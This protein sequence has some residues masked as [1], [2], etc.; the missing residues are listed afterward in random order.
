METSS[1][2]IW[3]GS[4]WAIVAMISSSLFP[5]PLTYINSR[6]IKLFIFFLI[7][8]T[9]LPK[10]KCCVKRKCHSRE[11][12]NIMWH[13]VI[14]HLTPIHRVFRPGK[15]LRLL[16]FKINTLVKF[17]LWKNT[18]CISVLLPKLVVIQDLPLITKISFLQSASNLG[19]VKLQ[20]QTNICLPSNTPRSSW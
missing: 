5:L 14:S 3:L 12:H 17:P 1:I 19:Q 18:L 16:Q 9:Y 13:F 15:S 11:F 10:G 2:H 4:R 6:E 7:W 8:A 20:S